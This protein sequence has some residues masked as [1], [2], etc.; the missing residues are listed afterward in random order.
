VELDFE[1]PAFAAKG[2]SEGVVESVET[3]HH[4]ADGG[5]SEERLGRAQGYG[6][7]PLNVKMQ[8]WFIVRDVS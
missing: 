4:G 1:V 6:H 5:E 3:L 8:W 2:T 7:S